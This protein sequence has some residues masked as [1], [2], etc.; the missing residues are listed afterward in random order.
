MKKWALFSVLL[1]GIACAGP[2][3]AKQDDM[4]E[5]KKEQ[6]DLK[7]R[8]DKMEKN[9]AATTH[10]ANQMG[11][12]ETRI[13]IRQL[14]NMLRQYQKEQEVYP[15][16]DPGE[17]YKALTSAGPRGLP[18]IQLVVGQKE[19]DF[20]DAWGNPIQYQNNATDPP[21]KSLHNKNRFDIYSFGPNG[22]D[23]KG[24]GDDI[25]NWE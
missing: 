11:R 20:L 5:V 12:K 15:S 1:T 3:D 7:K 24:G 8:V 19:R 6:A 16:D 25:N 4:K 10:V 2:Q 14:I 17:F 23:E 18:Y 21:P 13:L 22:K 9:L